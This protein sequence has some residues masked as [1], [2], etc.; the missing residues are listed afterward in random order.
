M[1]D[2]Y[3]GE[4]IHVS[5]ESETG[6][7]I[8]LPSSRVDEVCKLLDRNGIPYWVDSLAISLDEGPEMSVIS[9]SRYVDAARVQT[10]LGEA[11]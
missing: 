10:V 5:T 4:Q 9:F 6:P 8:D 7:Y 3:N 1:N 11:H 2:I